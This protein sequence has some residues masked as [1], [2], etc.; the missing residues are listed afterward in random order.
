MRKCFVLVDYQLD[1]LNFFKEAALL[2]R[3]LL[4]SL[5]EKELVF[6]LDKHENDYQSLAE[7][8][9]YLPHCQD[10]G[11]NMPKS[12]SKV[13][14]N[15]F[16]KNSFA[17]LDF[18]NFLTRNHFDEVEFAG[19]LAEICVLS[20]AILA[21]SVLPKARIYI[22]ENLVYFKDLEN[23]KALKELCRLNCIEFH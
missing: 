17:S 18:M 14:A 4:E 1:F 12:F 7:A 23:K 22:N 3:K 21:R 15:Y 13:K 10:E 19:L 11:S 16:Y 9:L 5:S 6:L 20:N 8:R 2:E